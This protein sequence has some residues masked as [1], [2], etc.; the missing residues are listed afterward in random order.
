VRI[1]FGE[2]GVLRGIEPGIH[3]GEDGELPGR[4]HRKGASGAE[5]ADVAGIRRQD[6]ITD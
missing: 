2:P 1:P 5:R 3:A 4:R 6:F